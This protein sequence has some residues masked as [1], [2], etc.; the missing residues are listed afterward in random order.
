MKG[1]NRLM[2]AILGCCFVALGILGIVIPGL[3]TVPFMI[4]ALMCFA[5]SSRRLHTWLY[6]H[7]V[8]GRQLQLWD[9]HHVIPMIAKVSS[10]SLMLISLGYIT[11]F[12]DVSLVVLVITAIF[13]VL[14]ATY[15][16]SKPSYP[17]SE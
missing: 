1:F 7:R 9:Q 6:H 14:G 5:K 16:L 12:T 15:I 11:I 10:I 3:P 2:L 4:L 17:P 13:M 8:F